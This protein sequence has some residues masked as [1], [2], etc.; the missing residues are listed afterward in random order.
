VAVVQAEVMLA[1]VEALG[2][3][4]LEVHQLQLE[5]FIQLQ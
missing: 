2:A 5:Q 3:S 1:A 4:L